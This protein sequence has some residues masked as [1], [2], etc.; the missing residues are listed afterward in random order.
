MK[1]VSRYEALDGTLY[2]TQKA[3]LKRD[4]MIQRI[5]RITDTWP[6]VP[7]DDN[8]NFANGHGYL[9]WTEKQFLAAKKAILTIL[10]GEFKKGS[11]EYAA[12][13]NPKT[14]LSWPCR[15]ADDMDHLTDRP[16]NRLYCVDSR[17]REWG[18][19][20]FASHPETG[21]QVEIRDGKRM[22]GKTG[23]QSTADVP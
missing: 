21:E 11:T 16:L 23:F 5:R 18:Q 2:D 19:P 8:C 20:Y 3:C 13:L 1:V 4:R 10:A 22:D 12:I 17:F 6:K 14:H 15:M 9:Q 7:D